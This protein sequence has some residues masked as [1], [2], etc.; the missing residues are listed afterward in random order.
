MTSRR[1]AEPT[2]RRAVPADAARVAAIVRAGM[3]E[4][5][6]PRTI[7]GARGFVQFLRDCFAVDA[8]HFAARYFV[9]VR[10]RRAIGFAETRRNAAEVFLNN[11]YVDPSQRGGG[12]GRRLL[13][14]ALAADAD[15]ETF[16]LDVFSTNEGAR[17]WYVVLGLSA[18]HSYDW[19]AVQPPPAGDGFWTVSGLPQADVVHARYGFSQVAVATWQGVHALGRIGDRVLR[20][21]ASMLQDDDAVAALAALGDGRE[22]YTIVDS[23]KSGLP[24]LST[25]FARSERMQ[26]R[27]GDVV[28]RLR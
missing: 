28:A 13:S 8:G 1:P 20:A 12:V 19:R 22:I 15:A 23:T 9:A 6:V 24:L 11:I 17:A 2:V 26:G 7:Y 21:E 10:G 25:A 16:A 18:L 5:V 27:F 3:P 4:P 14:A